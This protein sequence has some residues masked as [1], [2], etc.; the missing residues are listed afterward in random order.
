MKRYALNIV[1]SLIFLFSTA[2]V[3]GQGFPRPMPNNAPE[4]A[5]MS[6][7]P[8][9]INEAKNLPNDSWVIL[10]GY[11]VNMLPGGRQYTFRD[12]SGEIAVDIGPKEWRGLSAAASDRVQIHGEVKIHRGQVSIKVHAITGAVRTNTRQGQAVMRNQPVTVDEAK[13]L[14]HDS[15]VI[16]AGNIVSALPEHNNY[17]FRDPSGEI[18]VDI[19]PK[20]WRG[21][22]SDT[23]DR[24]EIHGEV[25][26]Q[27]G[28]VIIKVHAIRR[29][30][31]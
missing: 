30:G 10:T 4:R 20:E 8:I 23:S 31:V 26:I 12:P 29:M 1:L 14:P 25:K 18:A 3:H 24:V 5:V 19:G 9:M 13:N 11:I 6:N 17:T 2:I 7:R 21:L 16:L 28:Q 22:P 15:W 27:R